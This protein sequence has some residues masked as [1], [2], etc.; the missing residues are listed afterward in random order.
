MIDHRHSRSTRLKG[1]LL[2]AIL[3]FL[4]GGHRTGRTEWRDW[5]LEAI[6]LHPGCEG[7]V[8]TLGGLRQA[9]KGR[10]SLGDEEVREQIGKPFKYMNT[11]LKNLLK[12]SIGFIP[13]FLTFS[14]TKDWWVLAYLGAFIWFGVTGLRNIIQS[15]LGGGGLKR[16]P[17]LQWNSFISWSRIAD[18]LLY[19][20]FSVPLLDFL[21]KTQLL[22]NTFGVTTSTNP[23]LLYSVMALANGIYIST[24]NIFRGLPK[25]A[26]VGNFFRSILSIPLA[27]IFNAAL[28]SIMHSAMVPG[29]EEAL[30]KWAAVISKFASDCVAGVIEGLADRQTNIRIRLADY[31]AKLA[32]LFA[33]FARL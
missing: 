10:F 4:P 8:V 6:E 15:V 7:N 26:A 16:S 27:I 29:V 5:S 22:D 21:V 17:L 3:G 25:S 12:V 2:E 30:Q 11:G 18:S 14:L 32:L 19:T 31:K 1:N 23:I 28:S 20:G 13:A 24:H 33:L 9:G